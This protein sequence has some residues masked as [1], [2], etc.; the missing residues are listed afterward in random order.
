MPVNKNYDVIRGKFES[1]FAIMRDIGEDIKKYPQFEEEGLL[2]TFNETSGYIQG[3]N[4]TIK[5]KVY[6]IPP[7]SE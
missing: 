6:H 2:S 5:E 4:L 3:L 7:G 1:I